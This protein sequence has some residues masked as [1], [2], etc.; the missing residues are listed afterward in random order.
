[1]I[2]ALRIMSG[3]DIGN[4]N[5]VLFEANAEY[6]IN[7]INEGIS[8]RRIHRNLMANNGFMGSYSWFLRMCKSLLPL[9]EQNL[10]ILKSS[11]DK[12]PVH[13][14]SRSHKKGRK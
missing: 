11:S 4:K 14:S 3:M 12:K 8:K 10:D 2:E 6:I 13:V 5:R 1:M 7:S 9:C